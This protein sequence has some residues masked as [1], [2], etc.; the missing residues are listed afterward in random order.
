MGQVKVPGMRASAVGCG[1]NCQ[2]GQG[3]LGPFLV[4]SFQAG[5]PILNKAHI[6]PIPQL[7]GGKEPGFQLTGG[8]QATPF[9]VTG[10]SLRA[11]TVSHSF[12][13]PCS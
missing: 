3:Y 9:P 6:S 1:G 5:R 11:R 10:S 7:Q 4:L 8:R 2:G 13:N 12:C